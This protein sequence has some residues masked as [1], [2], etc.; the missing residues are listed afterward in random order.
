MNTRT[1]GIICGILSGFFW[2]TMDIAAQYLLHTACMATAPFISLTMAMTS[3]TL[4]AV[5][6]ARHPKATFTAVADKQNLPHL[7]LFGVLL[8]LTQVCFYVCVKHS[9]AQTAAVLAATR[10][11]FIMGLLVFAAVR[12]TASQALCCALALTGVAL[13]M[14]KGDFSAIS[15]GWLTLL[16]GCGAPFFSA[17]YTIQSRG[18]VR[19]AGLLITM[20]WAMLFV[21][22]ACNLYYPFWKVEAAWNFPTAFCVFWVA[23]MGH[24]V[25]Y[26]LYV[27]SAGKIPPTVTGVLETVEPLTAIVLSYLFFS[28]KMNLP[29]LIGAAM[30]LASV[31]LLG[32]SR[33]KHTP[34]RR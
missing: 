11:F 8:L 12:P 6:I 19:R 30:V 16:I 17:A 23:V 18:V 5:C 13:M 22:I 7:L 24:I 3:V 2:G 10:P 28:E 20:N 14:T 26:S 33:T 25:A 15:L 4:L 27:I 21:T 31:V 9:N 1:I 32:F 34:E 29:M